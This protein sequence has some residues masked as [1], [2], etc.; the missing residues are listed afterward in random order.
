MADAPG[1]RGAARRTRRPPRRHGGQ[2]RLGA[3]RHLGRARCADGLE[4]LERAAERGPRARVRAPRR[5]SALGHAGPA[6]APTLGREQVEGS[7]RRTAESRRARSP[8]S[9][10][11]E[12]PAP[13]RSRARR[14]VRLTMSRCSPV[15]PGRSAGTTKALTPRAPAPGRGPGEDRVEVR[16]GALEIH[17]FSPVSRHPLPSGSAAQLQR[18]GVRSGPGLGQ[19]ERGHRVPGGDGREPARATC[20]AC[21][22]CSTG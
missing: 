20:S 7:H 8:S 15:S 21:P 1:D 22:D 19:R 5:S 6:N 2:G 12:L 9:S 10:S 4:V 16:L 3:G 18:G 14:W 11:G 13:R 17:I